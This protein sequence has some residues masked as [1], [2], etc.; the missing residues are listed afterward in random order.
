MGNIF[1]SPRDLY[2]Q[3][4]FMVSVAISLTVAFVIVLS[5]AILLQ[6]NKIYIDKIADL[7]IVSNRQGHSENDKK[8]SELNA[9]TLETEHTLFGYLAKLRDVCII[10]DKNTSKEIWNVLYR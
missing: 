9:N 7:K 4:Y 2:R 6:Q 10:F 3:P 1:Y 8:L 5:A